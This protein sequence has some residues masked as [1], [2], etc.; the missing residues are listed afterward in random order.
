VHDAQA[1]HR[2]AVVN[3][4]P[5][6]PDRQHP[7]VLPWV[8]I[9]IGV[10]SALPVLALEIRTS[11]GP[12]DEIQ[13]VA[14]GFDALISVA[15]L[16]IGCLIGLFLAI[17]ARRRGARTRASAVALIIN[18]LGLGFLALLVL[19]SVLRAAAL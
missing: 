15:I 10:L 2:A 1:E 19:I 4:P 8:A 13:G 16:T 3:H 6:L 11:S 14:S 12:R 7:T 5:L 17:L 18:A 9:G